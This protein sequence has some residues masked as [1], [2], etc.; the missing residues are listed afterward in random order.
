[1]LFRSPEH[2]GKALGAVQ[3]AWAV[4]WGGAVLVSALVFTTVEKDLAW[5]VLFAIGLVPALLI[6]FIRRGITEPPRAI[7]EEHR[8][9]FWTTVAGIF[10]R[11]VLR[12][13]LVGGLF[14]IGAHG[15]YSALT[16]FLPTYLREVRQ[17]SVLGS[18]A[19]LTVIIV[20]RSEEH[21][22]ELQSH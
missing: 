19:Y 18:S 5:R 9:P 11:D 21:T 15:G 17:L 4:G 20:A 10:H 12:S 8:A 3:S 2:R 13:T 16:T 22:S 1:M 14:G 6:V 7:A